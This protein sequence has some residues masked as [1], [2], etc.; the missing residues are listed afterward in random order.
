MG[1]SDLGVDP[2]HARRAWAIV[3][4]AMR[5]GALE[6]KAVALVQREGLI[7]DGKLERAGEDEADL[8]AGVR[9][10]LGAGAAAGLD[11]HEKPFEALARGGGGDVLADPAGVEELLAAIGAD[12]EGR[13]AV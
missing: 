1:R 4:E 6:G 8:L 3:R 10:G 5:P 7:L 9:V 2:E 11:H 12:D 13:L